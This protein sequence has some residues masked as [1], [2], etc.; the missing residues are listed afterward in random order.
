[1]RSPSRALLVALLAVLL[2]LL[3]CPAAADAAAPAQARDVRVPR[4]PDDEPTAGM[5]TPEEEA[6]FAAHVRVLSPQEQAAE[7]NEKL[8]RFTKYL[9][10]NASPGC[11]EELD[12]VMALGNA[13]TG[14]ASVAPDSL[15]SEDCDLEFGIVSRRRTGVVGG[16][17]A[18]RRVLPLGSQLSPCGLPRNLP[19]TPAFAVPA[20]V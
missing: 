10:E 9:V 5:F 20:G 8:F 3:P 12:E 4:G 11:Q 1:M 2:V 19:S 7:Q 17:A 13:T 6:G 15:F 18:R 16:R 14:R